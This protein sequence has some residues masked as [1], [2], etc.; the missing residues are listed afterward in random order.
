VLSGAVSTGQLTSNLAALGAGSLP[1]PEKL[2]LAEPPEQYWATRAA[3]P[4]Q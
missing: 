4:W 3:R 1:G 2:G